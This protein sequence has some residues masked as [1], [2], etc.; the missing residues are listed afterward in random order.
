MRNH[1]NHLRLIR[2]QRIFLSIP[3]KRATRPCRSDGKLFFIQGNGN[4]L[5]VK[6]D[7]HPRHGRVIFHTCR[8]TLHSA[9][10]QSSQ[11][12]IPPRLFS[13]QVHHTAPIGSKN[14][15]YLVKLSQL[16]QCVQFITFK[17]RRRN[18]RVFSFLRTFIFCF[19]STP[20]ILTN[21]NNSV[22]KSYKMPCFVF[23]ILT[24]SLR[25]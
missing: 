24:G 5:S 10:C 9:W 13:P 12:S 6:W 20:L 1:V 17:I 25:S 15:F 7:R 11:D 14:F 18:L 23:L 16:C 3:D 4:L 21:P 8:H 2:Y 19:S 22:P